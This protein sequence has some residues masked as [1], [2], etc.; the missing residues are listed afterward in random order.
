MRVEAS[1]WVSLLLLQAT[2]IVRQ[3]A[4]LGV[5][6]PDKAVPAAILD[7]AAG[8]AI[9]SVAKVYRCP[10]ASSFCIFLQLHE[11]VTGTRR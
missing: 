7:G 2:N 8:F 10:N 1:E 11:E 5:S 9:L 4:A 6:A 3:F